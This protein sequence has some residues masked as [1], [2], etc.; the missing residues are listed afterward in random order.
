MPQA[1]TCQLMGAIGSRDPQV[2]STQSYLQSI[3]DDADLE[4]IILRAAQEVLWRKSA[5]NVNGQTLMHA[6]MS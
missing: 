4:A 1:L 2:S 6:T 3:A 5:A